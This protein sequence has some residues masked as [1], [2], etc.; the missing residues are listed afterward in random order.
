MKIR[1]KITVWIT[2]AALFAGAGLSG[3]IFH[4]LLEEPYKIIDS[5]LDHV[6]TSL[7]QQIQAKGDV[8]TALSLS[9]SPY[10]T[11]QYWLKISDA[12]GAILY[13]SKLG[14]YTDIPTVN[15][16]E[17]FNVEIPIPRRLMELGQD[18][19]NEVLFRVRTSQRQ[20]AGR[21]ITIA[22]AK[23]I[24]YFEEEVDQLLTLV[25]V[26]LAT[27][28][29]LVLI[30]SYVLAG[31]ILQPIVEISQLTRR[32]SDTSLDQRIPLG[33]NHDELYDLTV[34]LN[35]MFDRLQ[36]SFTRQRE[37]IGNA[38][39]ELKSPITLLLL[40]Q[41]E[42]AQ[43]L[44]ADDAIGDVIAQQTDI[45]HR[46]KGLVKN[47]LDLSR[48]EQQESVSFG[49][50]DLQ[51]LLVNILA[52]YEAM[53]D[54][55]S[56]IVDNRLHEPLL[57]NG[58]QEKLQRL[59]INLIDNAWRY[60]LKDGGIIRI[61]GNK[62]SGMINLMIDNPGPGVPKDETSRVFEQF[63]RLDKSRSLANGG[64]GLGLTIA[65]KIVD[66]HGGSITI[67]SEQDGWTRLTVSLT[68]KK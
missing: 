40:G 52:D 8:A 37:F 30:A 28:I 24:E 17:P 20:I 1:H 46:M 5:E 53:L 50:V 63:Y 35:R 54:N 27:Y 9:S 23:P 22:I 57:V 58:D 48:L 36:F 16:P 55:G 39:H 44:G 43:R 25:I 64:C 4:E 13:Q 10:P 62:R 59:F 12:D 67:G 18:I 6:T 34:A 3:V 68:A 47:L 42:L 66:L 56:I 32:I 29:M 11:E 65:K 38:A 61:T 45:L 26:G 60:N 19:D 15:H 51:K 2:A 31:R 21:D 41:E 33:R 7:F 14:K 49:Q